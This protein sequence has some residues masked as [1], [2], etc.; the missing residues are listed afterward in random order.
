MR[1]RSEQIGVGCVR[2]CACENARPPCCTPFPSVFRVGL[3]EREWGWSVSAFCKNPGVV[4]TYSGGDVP[5][6]AGSALKHVCEERG[7]CGR[8][9]R[10]EMRERERRDGFERVF[11]LVT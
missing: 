10:E 4:K 1:G 2:V 3:G 8:A 9:G 7:A 11:F 6:D 5:G